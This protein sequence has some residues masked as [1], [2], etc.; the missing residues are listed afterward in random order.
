[1]IS[2]AANDSNKKILLNNKLNKDEEVKS[3]DNNVKFN[4]F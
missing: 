1:M 2:N 4:F 3:D